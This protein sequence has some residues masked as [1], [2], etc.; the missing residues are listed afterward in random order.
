MK[1]WQ[2]FFPSDKFIGSIKVYNVGQGFCAY[3]REENG[4]KRI[5]FDIGL[6]QRFYSMQR[7]RAHSIPDTQQKII[8]ENYR[9]ISKFKPSVI[10]LSHWDIDHLL[11]ICQ[12]EE[13]YLPKVW[14][15]PDMSE[16][17]TKPK[18]LLR[19]VAFLL[20]CRKMLI[21]GK[22]LN[23]ELFWEN[24][25]IALYKGQTLARG[26]TNANNNQ[27]L[28][29]VIRQKIIF[30]GDCFYEAWP[31]ELAIEK[32]PYSFLIVPHHGGEAGNLPVFEGDCA[33]QKQQVAIV[34]YG[35]NNSYGHPK[36]EYITRLR[37]EYGYSIQR[38]PDS[39][40]IIIQINYNN[41]AKSL[42]K[43]FCFDDY[44][45]P[46]WIRTSKDGNTTKYYLSL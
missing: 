27:G 14:I 15:V 4:K 23:G 9:Y 31:T 11:G 8:E 19:V 43:M 18:F 35:E 42:V 5:L 29:A 38:M 37:E 2:K 13:A 28:I 30:P 34:S 24:E 6:D 1:Y 7:N 32:R 46:C 36:I 39:A 26:K 45:S 16:R 17:K 25:F 40:Y 22:E 20:Y 21:V 44:Q 12:I 33:E 41:D 3:L 10:I